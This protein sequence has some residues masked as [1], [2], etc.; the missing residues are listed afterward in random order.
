MDYDAL[1]RRLQKE[2]DEATDKYAEDEEDEE[3]D[4]EEEGAHGGGMVGLDMFSLQRVAALDS[5]AARDSFVGQLRRVWRRHRGARLAASAKSLPGG[6]DEQ[7]GEQTPQAKD[8][9]KDK[10]KEREGL[11]SREER[12]QHA[13][14]LRQLVG[15]YRHYAATHPAPPTAA[16]AA[17]VAPRSPSPSHPYPPLSPLP[18]S[19]DGCVLD[20]TV[21]AMRAATFDT[22]ARSSRLSS[23]CRRSSRRSRR[24]AKTATPRLAAAAAV[25]AA[26]G[27]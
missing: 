8:K 21:P 3:E 25:V 7:D 12:T 22:G 11:A 27:R 5:P 16:T 18:A 26:G 14:F 19:G 24:R 20:L 17:V 23:P 2:E 6:S 15:Q 9:D 10:E 1:R 13:Q 4:V